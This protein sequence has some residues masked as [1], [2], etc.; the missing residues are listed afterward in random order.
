MK[1]LLCEHLRVQVGDIVPRRNTSNEQK[2][3]EDGFA[4][5]EVAAREMLRPVRGRVVLR[6]V[7]GRLIVEI[8][9]D[10]VLL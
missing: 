8:D 4:N 2:V 6:N 10:R 5:P 7:A 1:R 3:R 9:T